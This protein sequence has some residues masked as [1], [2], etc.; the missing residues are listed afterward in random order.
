MALGPN[1]ES[2]ARTIGEATSELRVKAS[3]RR[4]SGV[5]PAVQTA[6]ASALGNLSPNSGTNPTPS[7]AETILRTRS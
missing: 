1:S 6:T 2:K 4:R 7:P 5:P 3:T